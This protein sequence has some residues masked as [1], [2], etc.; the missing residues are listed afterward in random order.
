MGKIR[1][2]RHSVIGRTREAG[3]R[4]RGRGASGGPEH[5]AGAPAAGGGHSRSAAGSPASP[6]H[7]RRCQ[8]AA[9]DS[10]TLWSGRVSKMGC[11]RSRKPQAESYRQLGQRWDS[12]S[13]SPRL[14]STRPPGAGHSMHSTLAGTAC[15]ARWQA[16]H[17]RRHSMH[18]AQHGSRE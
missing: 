7:P 13:C 4:A 11:N 2:R 5:G 9:R 6:A 1:K 16:Q 18:S 3:P 17:D 14:R 10:S 8:V 15:T 12:Q